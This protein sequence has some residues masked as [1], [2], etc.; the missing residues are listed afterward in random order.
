MMTAKEARDALYLKIDDKNSANPQ[1]KK[2]LA[3]LD[4]KVVE[5]IDKGT[6]QIFIELRDDDETTENW[7]TL[8]SILRRME[9]RLQNKTFHPQK[10]CWEFILEF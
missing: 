5:A 4:L 1:V 10:S 6:S 7:D 2:W 9:Y 8:Q 3:Y